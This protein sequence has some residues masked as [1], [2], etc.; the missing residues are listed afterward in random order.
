MKVKETGGLTSGCRVGTCFIIVWTGPGDG[1]EGQRFHSACFLPGQT[2]NWH[3]IGTACYFQERE[4][5]GMHPRSHQYKFLW[6]FFGHQG[7]GWSVLAMK[8]HMCLQ[9]PWAP[10]QHKHPQWSRNRKRQPGQQ[11]LSHS[12][13]LYGLRLLHTHILWWSESLE[14]PELNFLLRFLSDHFCDHNH[15]MVTLLWKKLVLS[16]YTQAFSISEPWNLQRSLAIP[17]FLWVS[18]IKR[19]WLYSA[20]KRMINTHWILF[21]RILQLKI[22]ELKDITKTNK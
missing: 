17:H 16:C 8:I 4:R 7:M 2:T 19:S 20:R 9:V 6:K 3:G 21:C 14:T 22:R 11:K 5:T 1:G 13:V 12:H 10:N 15:S 18:A